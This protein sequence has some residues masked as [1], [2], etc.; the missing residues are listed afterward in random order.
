MEDFILQHTVRF[1]PTV[2]F[3]GKWHAINVITDTAPCGVTALIDRAFTPIVPRKG[4]LA[5][6]VHPLV[7]RRCLAITAR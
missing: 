2:D 3:K 1:H 7:C 6:Q 5:S 4:G